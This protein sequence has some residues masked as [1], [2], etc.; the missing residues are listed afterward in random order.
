MESTETLKL[1]EW[2]FSQLQC[3]DP[4]WI[5]YVVSNVLMP[6]AA[7]NK[8]YCNGGSDC[9]EEL[10]DFPITKMLILHFSCIC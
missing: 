6:H 8:L 3:W 9:F 5:T 10:S 7:D 1:A 4:V 2:I